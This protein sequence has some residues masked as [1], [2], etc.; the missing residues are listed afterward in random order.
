MT[1]VNFWHPFMDDK[2]SH[3][4]EIRLFYIDGKYMIEGEKQINRSAIQIKYMETWMVT[5]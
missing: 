3:Y 5:H 4:H 1:V 2:G